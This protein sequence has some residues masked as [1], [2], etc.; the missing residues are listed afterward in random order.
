MNKELI[1]NSIRFDIAQRFLETLEKDHG[2]SFTFQTFLDE[3]F[4]K[5]RMNKL[6]NAEKKDLPIRRRKLTN[7][8]SGPFERC[9]G[10][11]ADLNAQ[12]AGVFVTVNKTDGKGRRA[13]NI[14]SVRALFCDKDDGE[15]PVLQLEPTLVV[16]S[17]RGDQAYWVLTDRMDLSGFPDA[18]RGLSQHLKSDPKICDLPRVMRMPGFFH[19]K[20]PNDPFLV[21]IKSV[22]GIY[23]SSSEVTSA[24][25]YSKSEL[26]V[27]K[28]RQS[29]TMRVGHS[30]VIEGGFKAWCQDLPV[31][32]GAQ[33]RLGGRNCTLLLLM[34][35][36]LGCNISHEEILVLAKEYCIRSGEDP[37]LVGDMFARQKERHL[38]EPFSTFFVN[39]QKNMSFYELARAYVASR[40]FEREDGLY[41]RSYQE[42]F[43]IYKDGRYEVLPEC[44]I[45]ADV[46]NFLQSMPETQKRSG[47][48]A[49]NNIMANLR[50]FIT[51]PTSVGFSSFLKGVP[52]ALGVR[53]ISLANGILELNK[54][55]GRV[56]IKML[57]HTPDFFS[58]SRLPFPFEAKAAFPIWKK[59]LDEMVPESDCQD[60]L[61]EWFGYNLILETS[62]QKFVIFHGDGANGKSV[63][64]VV[65]RTMLGLDNVSAVGL[66]QFDARRTFPLA[67]TIG[68]FANIIEEISE[69]DKAAEGILKNFV[70]GGVMTIERKNKDPFI[71]PAT[72]R[73]T[74]AC[75]V[76]PKFRDRSNGLWR[77]MIP[78]P[79]NVQIL[80]PKMQDKKLTNQSWWEAS[81]ELPGIFNWALA[82]LIRLEK[83]GHFEVP[84]SSTD[85]KDDYKRES[86]PA[87]T[88]LAENCTS[89][90]GRS[91][92]SSLLYLG[93]SRWAKERGYRPLGE[94]PFAREVQKIFPAVVLSKNALRQ[95][96]G[97][98]SRVWDQLSWIEESIG[99][100]VPSFL[101]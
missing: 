25:L 84:K 58:L 79:F 96:D 29:L 2:A 23:Y 91:I 89:K 53:H 18:Q 69:M 26:K 47:I 73:L 75:N 85:M 59:F 72:A 77:R 9:K 13:E 24:Y 101:D 27:E 33:N 61:Q 94:Q 15:L 38:T 1:K 76:L 90:A 4:D 39:K 31:E 48:S 30:G 34:R 86:N 36:G 64:C 80:D 44:D 63:V 37:E 32:A 67:A 70:T 97:G 55:D 28:Q 17:K 71:A 88:F 3:T 54:S 81:G 49:A 7:V 45:Q 74:I 46:I 6:S 14:A 93:Y 5:E 41:L 87:A 98:R 12:G 56:S 95:E 16:K 52:V 20:D 43:Y 62:Q 35:E 40:N 78:I 82:G 51:I 92:S 65:L 19:L 100:E 83:R 21:M 42:D 11:L 8:F 57:K 66:E 60:F 10:I 68:K 50:G 22:S 99:Y